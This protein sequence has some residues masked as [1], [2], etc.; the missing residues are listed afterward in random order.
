MPTDSPFAEWCWNLPLSS[1][2][3]GAPWPFPVLEILHIAGLVLVFGTVFIVDLRLLGRILRDEPGWQVVDE[4]MLWAWLGFAVQILTGPLLFIANSRK[5]YESGFF[6]TKIVLLAL[7]IAF[8][9]V[10]VRRVSAS[11][12]AGVSPWRG[13][14]AGGVSLALWAAVIVSGLSIELF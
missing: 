4:L 9:F 14:L 12:D 11:V 2:I 5:F 3:R 8:H 6:R 7:A 10:I 13:R 1:A